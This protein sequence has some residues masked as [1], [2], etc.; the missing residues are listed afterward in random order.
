MALLDFTTTGKMT[1]QLQGATFGKVLVDPHSDP[2]V[3]H[4]GVGPH[5][6]KIEVHDEMR[7]S[8]W[9]KVEIIEEGQP[10]GTM[11]VEIDTNTLGFY[12][13][14]QFNLHYGSGQHIVSDNFKS[15][16]GGDPRSS[17]SKRFNITNFV[18]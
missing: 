12:G 10:G 3:K 2:N 16:W 5:T 8:K 9:G 14:A 7:F 11:T 18:G 17:Q 15:G 4:F 13:T 6:L 1:I